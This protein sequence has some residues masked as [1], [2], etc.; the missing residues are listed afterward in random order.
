MPRKNHPEKRTMSPKKRSKLMRKG[1]ER[2]RKNNKTKTYPSR[3]EDEY[4][5]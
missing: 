1:L 2:G 5:F 4:G 3:Y